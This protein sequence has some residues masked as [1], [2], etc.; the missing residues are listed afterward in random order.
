MIFRK[1][2]FFALFFVFTALFVRAEDPSLYGNLGGPGD[3]VPA[4]ASLRQ[5]RLAN[6]LRYYI[7]ENS[8]PRGRAYLTL[9]VN[10][11]SVLE[12]EDQRGLAHFV[13]HMAFNGTRRFPEAELINYLRSLGMRFGPEVNAYTGFDATVYGI[14][15]PTETG[16]DG[17]KRIPE[18]ALAI[19]DD[20]TGGISFNPEDVD[21]ERLVVLEEH[22]TRLGASE[23]VWEKLL[24]VIY[25]GSRYAGRLPLGLP[26]VIQNAP[27]ERLLEFYKT[28][29]R[30]ENM[31]IILVG[32][33]DG[34]VLEEE[35]PRYFTAFDEPQAESG[36]AAGVSAGK[37]FGLPFRRPYYELPGPER[38]NITSEFITDPE[39]PFATVYLYYKRAP[40]ALSR[41]LRSYRES[42]ID[43]LVESMIDFRFEEK[44]ADE[45]SP[46]MGTGN[47][48]S[49]SGRQSRYFILAAESKEGM[50][51]AV[52][53][54]LLLEKE[55]LSRYGFTASEL[56]RAKQA[57][58][59]RL[60]RAV[61][62][63]DKRESDAY[64]QD[65]TAEFLDN[66][67]AAGAAWEL[68]A[69]LQLLS[70]IRPETVNAAVRSYFAEDDLTVIIAASDLEAPALPG[71]DAVESLVRRAAL[72]A[73]APPREEAEKSGLAVIAPPPGRIVSETADP[74]GAL[75]WELSNGGRMI[76]LET[77][78][79]N[80]EL[81][82]YALAKGGSLRPGASR[83]ED[84]SASL[85]AE[86]SSASGLGPHTR[87]EMMRILSGKEVS[88]SF[89]TSSYL[90]GFQGMAALKEDNL[91]TL[92]RMF[93]LSFTQ[94]RIDQNGFGLVTGQYRTSLIREADN[95]EEYFSREIAR[96]VYDN[97]PRL[98][99][100]E[101]EDIDLASAGAAL[102]FLRDALNPADYT[103][104][105]VGNLSQ[106]PE[107][108]DLAAAWL[109]S[110]PA[111][112][113][114]EGWT[115]PGFTRPGKTEKFV[116]KGREEKS[117]VYMG[118]FVSSPWNEEENA[119][120]QILNEYLYI[121]LSDEIRE[122]LG[123]VYSA[124]P[125]V[126]FSPMPR[127]ELSLEIY[128]ICDPRR[129]GELRGAVKEQL[130][131]LSR[132]EIDQETLNR[133]REARVKT[134][135]RYME[136]NMFI[137]RNAAQFSLLLELPLS[138]LEERPALYRSVG[139]EQIRLMVTDLLENG[140]AELVLL[141]QE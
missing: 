1:W 95:P 30:P 129:E 100:L 43:Y 81:A 97:H 139:S 103:F 69:V 135:E 47:W 18:R 46:Y 40:R 93:Y 7:L 66:N 94:P 12:E 86:L 79:R 45:S 10:A 22:R 11:G 134:F 61:A 57:L 113:A 59:S 9:A 133:A 115:D 117:M 20:W 35:L 62:E 127:G 14:E 137:A 83:A 110:I 32:D 52:L 67:Y 120:S 124:D 88:L 111:A 78:N 48:H 112:K 105:L 65:F 19:L 125:R 33:F 138:H 15:A 118:W 130:L 42:L 77:A 108:R 6:G 119:C 8:L 29:Y 89:W 104:V 96:L 31:A 76:L 23:R 98:K 85:A 3:M 4:M 123:G 34:K 37:L 38:G 51:G 27:A 141:P 128:F 132:G 56:D 26:E 25:R 101:V 106:A 75:I 55:A 80:N 5:G 39:L 70:G 107:L 74:S 60:E 109:A 114:V 63:K 92:F 13:E 90:R 50:T 121:V 53:D 28:W 91:E 131:A 58:V 87:P 24:P 41:D 122:K 102:N 84:I 136:N 82:L 73:I 126:S 17:V 36:S 99:P 21:N 44:L 140:P 64:I 54:E 71:K 116:R 2:R 72:T 16:E 49:R 68:E